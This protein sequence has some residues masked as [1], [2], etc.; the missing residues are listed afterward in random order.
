MPRFAVGNFFY[1]RQYT[2]ND[3]TDDILSYHFDSQLV[4]PP[5]IYQCYSQ[6]QVAYEKKKKNNIN[7]NVTNIAFYRPFHRLKE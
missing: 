5:M 7:R 6:E 4:K 2:T 3:E 1:Y